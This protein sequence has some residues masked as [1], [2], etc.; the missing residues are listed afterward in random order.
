MVNPTETAQTIGS[1][2]VRGGRGF[3]EGR[4]GSRPFVLVAKLGY[5]FQLSAVRLI[6]DVRRLLG[7]PFGC[8]VQGRAEDA[9][10]RAFIVGAVCAQAFATPLGASTP[11][12]VE[13]FLNSL[14]RKC[15]GG[16]WELD[17]AYVVP[18]LYMHVFLATR[19]R[20]RVCAAVRSVDARRPYFAHARGHCMLSV[21]WQQPELIAHVQSVVEHHLPRPVG[22]P[23]VEHSLFASA[24]S[25]AKSACVCA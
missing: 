2:K 18:A 12:Y 5:C 10:A 8:G 6:R 4:G 15:C 13:P 19:A 14:L 7:R 16:W 21:D 11:I 9:N 1:P 23:I 22:L 20:V 3:S 17:C 25:I 24:R